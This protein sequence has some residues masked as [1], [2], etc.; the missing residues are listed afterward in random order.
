MANLLIYLLILKQ[1]ITTLVMKKIC[2]YFYM[3]YFFTLTNTNYF[4][5]YR[6]YHNKEKCLM[7]NCG[8]LEK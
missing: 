5:V 1:N 3:T 6:L 2:I 8:I 4:D 7:F